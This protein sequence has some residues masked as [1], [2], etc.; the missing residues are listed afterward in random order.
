MNCIIIRQ[1]NKTLD[2]AAAVWQMTPLFMNDIIV[3]QTKFH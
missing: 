1:M 3:I 2:A